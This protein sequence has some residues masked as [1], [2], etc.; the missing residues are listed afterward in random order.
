ME[1]SR[2]R[3]MHEIQD[4]VK[5]LNHV[6]DAHDSSQPNIEPG[7]QVKTWDKD[8]LLQDIEAGAKLKHVETV[9]KSQPVI[10]P[11]IQLQPNHHK[12]LLEEVK[13]QA[14]VHS[15]KSQGNSP[16]HSLRHV[17]TVDK[18]KPII[19]EDVHLQK[20][21][22]SPFLQEVSS[23]QALRHVDESQVHDRSTPHIE[24]GTHIKDNPA[25]AVLAQLASGE[26]PPLKHVDTEDRQ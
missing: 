6:T 1:D 8:H 9:D 21:D 16:R 11:T 2:Q 3:L 19:P 20:V 17:E 24:P 12:D 18:S 4:G 15:I 25:K 13:H 26:L 7:T 14:V 5:P 23:P 10:D 22:R